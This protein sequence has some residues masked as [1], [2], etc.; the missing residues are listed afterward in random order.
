LLDIVVAKGTRFVF[1]LTKHTIELAKISD[2]DM[3]LNKP[4]RNS[5]LLAREGIICLI[6]NRTKRKSCLVDVSYLEFK[7]PIEGR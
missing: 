4:A 3:L 1:K 6:G 5:P 2:Y 7:P